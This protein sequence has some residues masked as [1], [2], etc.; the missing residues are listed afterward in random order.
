MSRDDQLGQARKAYYE[1]A[2][3][4]LADLE[5]TL[6]E[7]ETRPDDHELINR[8]FRSMHT[9]KGSGSMFGFDDIAMFTH[10]LETVFDQIR[11]KTL[12]LSNEIL[13][14]ALKSRDLILKMLVDDGCHGP[15]CREESERIVAALRGYLPLIVDPGTDQDAG[16]EA[17]TSIESEGGR[18]TVFR[19]R[20]KPDERI[21][22][23]G[24]NPFALLEELAELGTCQVVAR[25][26]NIPALDQLDPEACYTGWDII[27][28]TGRSEE[29][30]RDVFIFVEDDCELQVQV[31]E[32]VMPEQAP[33]VGRKLGEILLDRGDIRLADLHAALQQQ[34]LAHQ[35]LGEVLTTA[36]LVS[37]QSV[38]AA[39]SEQ[40][41]VREVRQIKTTPE[42]KEATVSSIRVEAAKLDK[43]GDLVGEL[44]I[45]QARL[46]QI[47]N[48]RHDSV[49]ATLAEEL[50]RLSDELRD[51]TLGIRMLPI[52]ST[53]NKF[54]RL[55]RDLSKELGKEI[56]LV[57]Q[58][59]ETELDKNVIE[60]LNDPLVHLLRNSID[61]GVETPD[62]RQQRGKQRK[63]TIL[64]SAEHASGE[65][66][67]KIMDDGAGIDPHK[68]RAKALERG[69]IAQ[70]AGLAD[71]EL[72]QLVFAPGFSTA[73]K[74]SN[75]SGR[76]VGMDVVKRGIDALRG[77]IKL[78][79]VPNQG[80]TVT[81][82]LPLT[83]AIIDG[84]QVEV[85]QNHYVIPL[86]SVEECVELDRRRLD[87]GV[88]REMINLRG[89]AVPFIRLRRWFEA[90]GTVP[91]IEQ[92]VIV[93]V[94]DHRVGLVVD[95][96]IGQ[97]QTVIKSLGRIYRELEGIS[98]ATVNGD[99]TMALIV[100]VQAMVGSVIH[101]A[102]VT[103]H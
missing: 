60:K 54:L 51:N 55:V 82:K 34:V 43:L 68:V 91:E 65:V 102:G 33:S 28:T 5:E 69:L 71:E 56:E 72:L 84:L 94:Q 78:D 66:I 13:D 90:A 80:T 26:E 30:I 22:H 50:E 10:E 81:V 42:H 11:N 37:P 32:Q 88:D 70:D 9:I 86:S 36:G 46:S 44:V 61:H 12:E 1:E 6:L 27:L 2:Q 24:T 48:E 96:V 76:G 14:L 52:G 67:I 3:E 64:L 25:T 79:S 75:V 41:V 57:T 83:L 8:A 17:G 63:G 97:H 20:F 23:S 93:N 92:I 35:P 47:V 101:N 38:E 19:I 77:R 100:D 59:G 53:F 99:G 15:E 16:G 85:A 74:V 45:V 89:E 21:F 4:L 29:A 87:M 31:V 73:E 18:L 103:L 58:G 62:V 98:G 49:L 40:R 7:L 39:L 95:K